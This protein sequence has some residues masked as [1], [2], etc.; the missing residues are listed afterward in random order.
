VRNVPEQDLERERRSFGKLFDF[1]KPFVK[2]FYP[3]RC[4]GQENIPDGPAVV[5]ANHSNYIDPLLVALA[6]GKENYMHFMA[7]L[8]LE[9]VPIVG[10]VLKKCGICFVDRGKSDIDAIRNMMRYLK[11]GE[12]V[13]MFPEGTRVEHDNEVEAKTGAVRIA[14][15]MKVPIVPVYIPRGKKIFGR[16]ELRIGKPYTVEGKTHEEYE[17]LADGIMERIY[18]LRD[19]TNG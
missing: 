15:K 14:S 9:R 4:R 10:P 8:E 19:G 2:A 5:C 3:M 18:E 1:L 6:F 16:V 7:K 12:K 11:H 17:K 13:F